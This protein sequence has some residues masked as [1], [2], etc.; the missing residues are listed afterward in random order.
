M[1]EFDY[2]VAHGFYSWVPS[3]VRERLMQ[4]CSAALAPHGVAFISYNTYPGAYGLRVLR[5]A[6]LYHTRKI[7]QTEPRIDAAI[8]MFERLAATEIAPPSWRDWIGNAVE[9]ALAHGRNGI[10]HDELED[11]NEPVYFHQFAA[12]AA[13]HGLQYLGEAE[14]YTMFDHHGAIAWVEGG[15]LERE[16]YLDFLRARRFRQTL[17]CKSSVP[18]RRDPGPQIMDGFLFSAP[19]A[20]GDDG[21]L[22]GLHGI[23]ISAANEAVLSV[24]R[25]LGETFP[26]PLAFEDLVPYAGSAE[27]LRSILFGLTTG[28]F[29]NLHVYDFPCADT[30]SNKPRASRLVRL[31]ATQSPFVTSLCHYPV[32]LDDVSRLIVVALDGT[33]DHEQLARFLAENAEPADLDQIRAHLPASLEWLAS[34]GLLEA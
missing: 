10:F 6:A 18:L 7:T 29:A 27:A 32:E 12:H 19:A 15:I 30:V 28:G 34:K 1:G 13:G 17:L 5:E 4:I 26:L 3:A 8:Q 2:I 9:I 22:E 11:N 14:L 21:Q 25:A 24:A 23:R 20:P 31:Q 16:Q 33:R